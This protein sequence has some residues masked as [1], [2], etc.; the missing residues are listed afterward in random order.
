MT[1]VD[2]HSTPYPK[3]TPKADYPAMEERVLR[4]WA[5]EGIFEESVERRP[6]GEPSFSGGVHGFQSYPL[7]IAPPIIRQ[8]LAAMPAEEAV[9]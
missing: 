5:A 8:L 9:G 1:T 4:S 3:T 7:A 6:A 2:P